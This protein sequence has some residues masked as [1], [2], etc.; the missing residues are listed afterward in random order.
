MRWPYG[1]PELFSPLPL[2]AAVVLAVN[3]HL[4]KARFH[5][6]LTGKLSDL[7]GCFVLPLFV[8]ALLGLATRWPRPVRLALGGLVT[9]ALFVPVKLWPSAADAVCAVLGPAARGVGFSGCRIVADPTDLWAL[10][11]IALA[12]HHGWTAARPPPLRSTAS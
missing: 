9:V 2:A 6:A 3:D 1:L 10:P 11:F 7:A 8:S 4:P 12:L 5:N